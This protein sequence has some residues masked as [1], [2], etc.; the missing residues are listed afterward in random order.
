MRTPFGSPVLDV[1]CRLILPF[2]LLF[3]AYIIVHGH[4][5]PGGGFQGG[6]VLAAAI[7]LIRMVR[8]ADTPW[9]LDRRK[10]FILACLGLGLFAGIGF[11]SLLF[12]GHYL[13]YGVLPLPLE[14]AQRRMMG[15]FGIEV[16]VAMSVTGVL[17]LI[18]DALI[19][20]EIQEGTDGE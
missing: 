15:S 6:A 5:S 2:I 10:A 3:A 12:A 1:A 14:S 7:M 4:E 13:D 8:G 18:F 9:A 16:G 19:E 17:V 11:L 20:V